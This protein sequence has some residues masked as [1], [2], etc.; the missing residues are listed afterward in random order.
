MILRPIVPQLGN[1]PATK[2]FVWPGASLWALGKQSHLV[3]IREL[4]KNSTKEGLSGKEAIRQGNMEFCL[5][6]L[7]QCAVSLQQAYAGSESPKTLLPFPVS[8]TRS[9]Y[10]MTFL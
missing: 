7:K 9:G 8:L 4:A 2:L 1:L 6:S 3:D 10:P 5:L